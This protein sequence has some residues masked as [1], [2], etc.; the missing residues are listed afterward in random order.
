[1]ARQGQGRVVRIDATWPFCVRRHIGIDFDTSVGMD[2]IKFSLTFKQPPL[3]MEIKNGFQ[4]SILWQL[5]NFSCQ[6]YGDQNKFGH[7]FM[8]QPKN[9]GYH[10]RGLCH[11]FLENPQPLM[12]AFQKHM[13]CPLS[14]Q[15]K[16]F[17]HHRIMGVCWMATKFFQ[18]P[19]NT[20]PPSN[21][22]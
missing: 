2:V 17:S 14:Q 13:T 3:Q 8:W 19:S 9:F 1:M 11:M 6:P 15:S 22:N 18:S 16:K 7:P 12:R 4:S 20:P 21:G 10:K 5:Q